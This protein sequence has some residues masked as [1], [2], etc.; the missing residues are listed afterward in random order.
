MCLHTYMAL[1]S[2][3]FS[4]VGSFFIS[5]KKEKMHSI[6]EILLVVFIT[7]V[8]SIQ[9]ITGSKQ[10]LGPLIGWFLLL[11]TGTAAG[12][13]WVLSPSFTWTRPRATSG[14]TLG[15]MALPLALSAQ[16]LM[17]TDA[18]IGLV[19]LIWLCMI[20]TILIIFSIVCYDRMYP[21]WSGLV[22]L[23]I[24]LA[25][26]GHA[27]QIRAL[28]TGVVALVFVLNSRFIS[29][30]LLHSF[31]LGEAITVNMAVTLISYNLLLN[32]VSHMGQ[33]LFN[34]T[35][36]LSIFPTDATVFRAVQAISFVVL[37]F[38]LG[39]IPL[40]RI[41]LRTHSSATLRKCSIAPS[42]IWS[43]LLLGLVCFVYPMIWMFMETEPFMWVYHFLMTYRRS[44]DIIPPRIGFC[45]YFLVTLTLSGGC[46]FCRT[47]AA[48]TTTT[49]TNPIPLTI[50]RKGYH[51]LVVLLF[52]PAIVLEPLFMSLA[53]AVAFALFIVMEYLRIACMEPIGRHLF[54]V[55]QKYRDDKDA[56][57]LV[58]TP[59]YLLVGCA[60]PVWLHAHTPKSHES[61]L[62]WDY[63]LPLLSGIITL[64]VGDT[65][66]SV[67]GT[68]YGRHHWPRT[69]KTIEGTFGAVVAMILFI[70]ILYYVTIVFSHTQTEWIMT[71]TDIVL[72][73]VVVALLEAYTTQIDNLYLPLYFYTCLL[74]L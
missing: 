72:A 51:L 58:L 71:W 26:I 13:E 14:I 48:N 55:F 43:G 41:L 32:L 10:T 65:A 54:R 9:L 8:L 62:H 31:T 30:Q 3:T 12:V 1:L 29:H 52:T 11:G 18:T 23:I 45:L 15:C 4:P 25:S 61:F 46:I 53:F 19:R 37:L 69:R 64:G 34:R 60:L 27:F 44:E 36:D 2:C 49:T 28:I 24:L 21:T 17:C 39:T 35:L 74:I 5:K 22:Y 56:G 38:C 73:T 42:L 67:V 59:T 40:V 70:W 47:A 57:S 6:V 7:S 33:A 66:A 68:L 16:W 20:C 63:Y 50:A